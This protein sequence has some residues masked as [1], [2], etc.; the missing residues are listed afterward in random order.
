MKQ[1]IKFWD[2][3]SE[4]YDSI[5]GH[6]ITQ[7]IDKTIWKLLFNNLLKKDKLKILDFGCGT[8][9]LS[10]ILSESGHDV[11]GIDISEKMIN[12]SKIKNCTTNTSLNFKKINIKNIN[13]TSYFD[14]VISRHVF[15]TL[16]NPIETLQKIHSLLKP[17]GNIIIIDADW[18]EE[19]TYKNISVNS[20]TDYCDDVKKNLPLINL[21]RPKT[22]FILLKETGFCDIHIINDLLSHVS[23]KFKVNPEKIQ[24][25]DQNIS[26]FLIMASKNEI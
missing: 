7:D 14:L 3:L 26:Q 18:Y 10:F 8:G 21:K 22:D 20:N 11:L 12:K 1:I 16:V 4:S 24:S 6:G 19:N 5:P 2:R 13:K 15:W 23:S 25:F 9:A 17:C